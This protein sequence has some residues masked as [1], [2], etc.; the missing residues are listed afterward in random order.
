MLSTPFTCCS[1]GVATACSRVNASAPTYVASISISGGAILG[2]RATGKVRMVMAP[3]STMMMA[4]TIAT[5]GRLMKN[6]DIW[7]IPLRLCGKRFGVYQHARAHLLHALGNHTFARFQPFRN[8]P[9]RPD[10]VA[11]LDCPD[12]HLVL[13]IYN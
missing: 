8:N 6:F 11:H 9:L 5:M 10:V 2:N 4:I 1:M 12:A 3:T 13:A 7:L